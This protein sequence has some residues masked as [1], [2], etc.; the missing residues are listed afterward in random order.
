M[1]SKAE[2][3]AAAKDRIISLQSQ[4][5]SRILDMAAEVEKLLEV[6]TGREA[7]EFLR[8]RCNL[9]ASELST[10]VSFGDKLKGAEPL[11]RRSRVSFSV[12]KS[13]VAADEDT[14]TEV[15][16]RMEIGA[17]ID[18]KEI[19]AIRKRIR[20]ARLT[21]HDIETE[22][23]A[24]AV[25]A[26]ALKKSKLAANDFKDR[27]EDFLAPILN[28]TNAAN[29]QAPEI[30]SSAVALLSEFEALF[31]SEH[32]QPCEL[33]AASIPH[34]ISVAHD[35]LSKL[36]Q[37][38]LQHP[39]RDDRRPNHRLPGIVELKTFTGRPLQ[40]YPRS[41]TPIKQ[42]PPPHHRLKALELCAGAGGLSLGLERAGFEHVA[43]FE[44][45][46]HAA[47]T[48]RLNRP[49]WPVIEKDI[50]EVDFRMFED[51]EVDLVCGGLPCQPYSSDGYG[52]G[53]D[54][55]RDLL[56]EGV[57]IVTQVK[58][59]AFLFENVDGLLQARHGDHVARVLQGFRRAGYS[60]DIHR[61]KAQDF[62]IAQERSRVLIV[63]VRNEYAGAFRMPSGFPHRRTNIG[64]ALVDLMAEN[65]WDGAY[66]WAHAR[67]QQPVFGR[68]GEV[69]GYG[70]LASTI[71]T[72]R[73]K[74]R[75]KEA[76][77]WGGKCVDIAGLPDAAPTADDAAKP[78][79]MPALTARMRARLQDFPDDW[80][81]VGGKQ[82]TAD[83]IGNA[84][85]VRMGTAVALA[86]F[87]AIKGVRWDV[88]SML[89]PLE[90]R[91]L[92]TETPALEP[93]YDSH[94]FA[95]SHEC[96]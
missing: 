6:V 3:L 86:L 52:L 63:G 40:T 15:I 26:A 37:G 41:G 51:D 19:S 64:A 56:P 72:R 65:G 35:T 61:A 36:A 91:V 80:Q 25:G 68:N 60:V 21:P 23:H 34:G 42:P 12:L 57:R 43:I 69:V 73:G 7:R 9:P 10:Y 85:P 78:G 84:V 8:V 95:N 88:E 45:D 27:L 76:A 49:E 32:R 71:V 92:V 83:Q 93:N 55:P 39:D 44:F 50:R 75:E 59:K 53:K 58:P 77:R 16:E 70:A 89:W 2:A 82:A 38:T 48:L 46:K 24:K 81:F 79:F 17:R 94:H 11:L 74:P 66:D 29:V 47:A 87:A 54:D 30:R 18:A 5:T 4:M 1:N 31:G 28:E 90:P 14:R 20:L 22:R 13:L 67:G 33:K 62:G 96:A